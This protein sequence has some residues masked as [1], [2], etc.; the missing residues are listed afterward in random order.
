MANLLG[1]VPTAGS[2][3]D[4]HYVPVVP[5]VVG[6]VVVWL[7]WGTGSSRY[8]VEYFHLVEVGSQAW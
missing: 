5:V 3:D 7:V 1:K 6:T 4:R 8:K 2:T